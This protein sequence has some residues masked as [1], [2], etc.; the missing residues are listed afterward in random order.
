MLLNLT[1]WKFEFSKLLLPHLEIS[2]MDL[3]SFINL[4]GSK[5]ATKISKSSLYLHCILVF[6]GIIWLHTTISFLWKCSF[7]IKEGDI[8]IW[9]FWLSIIQ[10]KI[11]ERLLCAPQKFALYVGKRWGWDSL[12]SCRV[13]W[14]RVWQSLTLA[15]P[16]L[17]TDQEKKTY[18]SITCDS[19]WT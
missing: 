8:N 15:G 6:S 2:V 11:S 17:F 18:T 9:Q 4:W 13:T 7:L 12:A 1:C 19:Q 3:E 14:N 16:L 10:N 5:R